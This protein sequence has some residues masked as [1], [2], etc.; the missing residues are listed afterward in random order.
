M[1][2]GGYSCPGEKVALLACVPKAGYHSICQYQWLR[3]DYSLDDECHPILYATQC[4]S[5]KCEVR[6]QD[7]VPEVEEFKFSIQG[8]K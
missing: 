1:W 5:Y 4:G 8:I 2:T 6:C 3:D 7:R